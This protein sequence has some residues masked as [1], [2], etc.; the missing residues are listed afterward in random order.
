MEYGIYFTIETGFFLKY[1]IILLTI[2]MNSILN[3]K[4][5]DFSVFH[6]SFGF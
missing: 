2:E 1:Q 4:T 6:I 5:I 3:V